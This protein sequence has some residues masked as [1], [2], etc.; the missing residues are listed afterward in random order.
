MA[1][2]PEPFLSSAIRLQ[3][4]WAVFPSTLGSSHE[5]AKSRHMA[6]EAAAWSSNTANVSGIAKWRNLLT[7]EYG[8][9]EPVRRMHA[10]EFTRASW[11][12]PRCCSELSS[13]EID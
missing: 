8:R 6:M 4:N 12:S 5:N 9:F 7:R 13:S 2:Y 1:L 10:S 11:I 3:V